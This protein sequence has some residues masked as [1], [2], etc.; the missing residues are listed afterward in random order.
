MNVH[1]VCIRTR[2]LFHLPFH[3]I[4]SF[5]FLFHIT[6][7]HSLRS[8]LPRLTS[9]IT[10]TR[11]PSLTLLRAQRRTLVEHDDVVTSLPG[12][13]LPG[14]TP[15]PVTE[16]SQICNHLSE[17]TMRY[18][19]LKKQIEAMDTSPFQIVRVKGKL[20]KRRRRKP[21]AAP[22]SEAIPMFSADELQG[23]VTELRRES[24]KQMEHVHR[25]ML[26]HGFPE[27][28]SVGEL[29]RL[30]Y[31]CVTLK[32]YQWLESV[33]YL[34]LMK[35]LSREFHR[36]MGYGL[37]A[38]DDVVYIATFVCVGNY[39]Y[40]A[41]WESLEYALDRGTYTQLELGLV[42]SMTTRLYQTQKFAQ[43]ET[44][45]LRRLLLKSMARRVGELVNEFELPQLM[46]IVQCYTI[47]DVFPKPIFDLATRAMMNVHDY[48]PKE[49]AALCNIF[50]KWRIL[51]PEVCERLLE[52][53]AAAEKLDVAMVVSALSAAR[54]TYRRLCT[55]TAQNDLEK[56]K[57]RQQA[58]RIANRMNEL[59]FKDHKSVLTILNC[60]IQ[61]RLYLPQNIIQSIF[62]A[63]GQ[64]IAA[65]DIAKRMTLDSARQLLGLLEYFG[66]EH[67]RVLAVKLRRMFQDGVLE[68]ERYIL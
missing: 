47:H 55:A 67:S 6:P 11:R 34:E 13:R 52:K 58:E 38:Q 51:T 23:F 53:I 24:T 33:L 30:L 31:Y 14:T 18:D 65:P 15:E 19:E 60:I 1:I 66:V 9:G 54:A 35:A 63:T 46:R 26:Q 41:L 57:I 17:A 43:A 39:Y 25:L 5:S 7:M 20:I 42:K 28:T 21:E 61:L 62:A 49:S 8:L 59:I 68:E 64:L 16:L 36:R 40:K 10:F 2:N 56:Q 44:K 3:N 12:V 29:R 27:T 22:D 50:L 4:H 32:G 45:D 48:N 37:L